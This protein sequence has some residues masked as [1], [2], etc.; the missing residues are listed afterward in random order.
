MVPGGGNGSWNRSL[1]IGWRRS[2]KQKSGRCCGL[3]LVS[4]KG[5]AARRSFFFSWYL[6]GGLLEFLTVAY[7]YLNRRSY[8]V[9][10][11]K[12]FQEPFSVLSPISGLRSGAAR[13]P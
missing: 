1:F 8:H 9:L 2:E 11:R 3:P 13:Q 12:Q 4:R 7:L 10:R 6:M 5:R